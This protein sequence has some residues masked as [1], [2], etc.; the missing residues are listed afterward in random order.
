MSWRSEVLMKGTSGPGS[1]VTNGEILAFL[2]EWSERAELS[3]CDVAGDRL[4]LRFVSLPSELDE[5][6]AAI[7]RVCPDAVDRGFG[8]ID[9]ALDE[10]A[11]QGV[12]PPGEMLELVEGLDLTDRGYGLVALARALQRDRSIRLLW[13]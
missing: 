6:A 13:D 1:G 7:Y 3:V 11:W 5:L 10:C 4:T 8:C 9:E 2:D 12:E